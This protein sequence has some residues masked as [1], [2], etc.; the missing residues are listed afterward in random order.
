VTTAVLIIG[1]PLSSPDVRHHV[2][3]LI[4]D[5]ILYV[6]QDR[7]KTVFVRAVD[8]ALLADLDDAEVIHFEALGLPG[9]GIRYDMLAELAVRACKTLGVASART[10]GR[11]PASV[12]DALRASGVSVEPDEEFFATRRRAKRPEQLEGCRRAVSAVEAG[13][14]AIREALRERSSVTAEE[15]QDTAAAAIARSRASPYDILIVP[16]GEDSVTAHAPGRGPVRE[17]EP[18]IVDLIARDR[19]TGMY[20][21]L[22]RTFCRGEQPQELREYVQACEQ[23]LEAAISAV[24]PGMIGDDLN[25]VASEVF[26][27][28]G[29]ATLRNHTSGEMEHGFWHSLGHGVGLEVHEGP[30]LRPGSRSALMAGEVLSLEPA[31]YRKGF[32]GCR[33][34]DM[35]VVTA[36]GCERLTEYP[37]S[38]TP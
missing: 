10:P 15:L 16:H 24:R 11:F 25:A 2:P 4:P 31:L 33:L 18:V 27:A 35:V 1:D 14:D 28:A 17:G 38:A 30:S 20:A 12:A 13:W 19:A 6:E 23:A 7:G 9:A 29:Y 21:D 32:G 3:V 36:H 22:T 5:P 8:A 34:E 26:E 37:R